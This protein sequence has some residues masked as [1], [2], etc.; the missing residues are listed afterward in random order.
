MTAEQLTLD[1]APDV[2]G[3]SVPSLDDRYRIWLADNPTV[4]DEIAATAR[5]LRTAGKRV[6]IN[7]C[8]EEMRERVHTVGDKYVLNNSYR[9]LAARDVMGHYPDLNGMFRL[10]ERRTP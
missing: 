5:Q 2:T 4:L 9:A 3:S 8:F 7:R 1:A 6:S 10:R